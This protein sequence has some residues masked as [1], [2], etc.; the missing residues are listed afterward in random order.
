MKTAYFDCFAGCGGDM[1]VAAMIDAGL[2]AD[3]LQ[4]R[5]DS[6]SIGDLKIEVEKVMRCGISALHFTPAA[7][8]EQHHR[9]LS[10]II[11]IIDQSDIG[12]S[13]KGHAAD[14]FSKLAQVEGRIHAKDVEAI[15][16]H[17]VGA[18]DSIVDIVSACVGFDALG[19]QKVCCS[20]LSVGGGTVQSAHGLLPAPAPATLELLKQAEA[21]IVGGPVDS[22]LLTPTAA[23]ILTHFARC[24]GPM[25]AMKVHATGY[26]AGTRQFD[27]VPNVLRLIVGQTEDAAADTDCVCL[28]EC[29]I[30]D[31]D[32]ET[33]G[34]TMQKL[35]DNGAADVFTTAI[36]MKHNRPAVMLSVIS[37]PQK[38]GDLERI[39]FA[40]GLTLGIRRQLVSRS[41]LA[42]Q[43]VTVRTQF[44][45]VRIKTGSLQGRVVS[46][47]P[48]YAD[49]AAAAKK[50]GI[51]LKTVRSAAMEAFRRSTV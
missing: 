20:P 25:P 3:F 32:G 28:L 11:A 48:E 30:D 22:E 18:V 43:S 34:F 50:H 51:S 35:L 13:A 16:F 39:I 49:C 26:G 5:L 15:H 1:I 46:A 7:P 8:G 45:S 44:G 12:D 37:P 31:A 38:A 6:L 23:A 4:N 17:E 9:K 33:I 40:E 47:K 36:G 24:F 19:L 27:D 21:P 42:R 2:D 41:K 10:D 14:I 29:N